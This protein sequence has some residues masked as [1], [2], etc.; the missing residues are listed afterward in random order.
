M[1]Q[2]S[3]DP[4]EEVKEAD[5]KPLKQ[6]PATGKAANIKRLEIGDREFDNAKTQS[7]LI[8]T[9]SSKSSIIKDFMA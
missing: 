9:P 8:Q 1:L 2:I 3:T 4:D 7:S 5:M 6:I